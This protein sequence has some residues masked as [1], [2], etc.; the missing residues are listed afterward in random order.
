[1][2][3]GSKKRVQ[4]WWWLVRFFIILFICNLITYVIIVLPFN[5]ELLIDRSLNDSNRGY[6]ESEWYLLLMSLSGLIGSLMAFWYVKEKIE[7]TSAKEICKPDVFKFF[8]GSNVGFFIITTAIGVMLILNLVSFSFLS[9]S[10]LPKLFLIFAMVA[11][12]EEIV[13]RG[14]ILNKLLE[15]APK[16]FAIILSALLFSALHMA[17]SHFGIIGFTN[18]FLSGVLLAIVYLHSDNLSV[19]IGLHFSWNLIQAILGFAVSG[20]QESGLMS[21]TYNSSEGIV[22]GGEFGLEGSIIL[23]PVV[24][25]SI[26]LFLQKNYF[27]TKTYK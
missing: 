1:M 11:I 7:K 23:I 26:I 16:N 8:Q 20:Y 15:R 24:L 4:A 10:N 2:T 19:P 14:Y 22:T 12:S 9:V 18:I 13:F 6:N 21:I 5:F 17:N 3:E 25:I 27:K